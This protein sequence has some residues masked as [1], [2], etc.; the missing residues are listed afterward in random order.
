MAQDNGNNTATLTRLSCARPCSLSQDHLC[1]NHL[2][3]PLSNS[4]VAWPKE[5]VLVPRSAKLEPSFLVLPLTAYKSGQINPKRTELRHRKADMWI[6]VLPQQCVLLLHR[7]DKPSESLWPHIRQPWRDE[8]IR[9]CLFL[10]QHTPLFTSFICSTN[11]K[12]AHATCQTVSGDPQKTRASCLK[13]H[14]RR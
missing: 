7:A 2:Q 10:P 11:G 9:N 8:G 3:M 13:G 12:G 5:R 4:A 14:S 6:Q 1:A